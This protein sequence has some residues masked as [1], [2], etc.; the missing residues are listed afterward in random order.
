[1]VAVIIALS[2]GTQPQ[3]HHAAFQLLDRQKIAIDTLVGGSHAPSGSENANRT[4]TLPRNSQDA[5]VARIVGST[6]NGVATPRGQSSDQDPDMQARI[7]Q[8]IAG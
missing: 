1:M 6:R 4:A 8:A 5:I 2:L 7:V 3:I